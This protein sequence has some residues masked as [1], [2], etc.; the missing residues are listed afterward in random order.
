ML[1]TFTFAIL[2]NLGGHAMANE[3]ILDKVDLFVDRT[4]QMIEF[5]ES[6]FEMKMKEAV[7]GPYKFYLG[8]IPGFVALQFVP[9]ELS[10]VKFQQNRHQFN[11]RVKSLDDVIKKAL[12]KGGTQQ[13]EIVKDGKDRV[14]SVTD[15]DN[16]YIVFVGE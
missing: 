13:G 7:N 5:Y 6:V 8:K 16:N 9:E 12:S 10:G 3:F 11:F 15:P 1:R 2:L 4:P 14:F